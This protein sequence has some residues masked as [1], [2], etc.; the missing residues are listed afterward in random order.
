M[1]KALHA[2]TGNDSRRMTKSLLKWLQPSPAL[3]CCVASWR[4][5]CIPENVWFPRWQR[6]WGIFQRWARLP[7]LGCMRTQELGPRVN[8]GSWKEKQAR[9]QATSS[10][11]ASRTIPPANLG[12]ILACETFQRGPRSAPPNLPSHCTQISFQAAV[13]YTEICIFWKQSII[14]NESKYQLSPK[15]HI[16]FLMFMVLCGSGKSQ[17]CEKTRTVPRTR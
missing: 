5:V 13:T 16:F 6:E 1:R 4:D 14:K 3:P 9:G 11:Q 7:C 10:M 17:L 2:G 12:N 15:A 8:R